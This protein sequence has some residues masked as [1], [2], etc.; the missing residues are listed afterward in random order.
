MYCTGPH[1][2][3]SAGLLRETTPE[4]IVEFVEAAVVSAVYKGQDVEGEEIMEVVE[5]AVVSAVYEMTLMAARA[6]G[7]NAGTLQV[8]IF[9]EINSLI[10]MATDAV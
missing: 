8:L 2:G 9:E 7:S 4:E 6:S 10:R 5:A 1:D 3:P